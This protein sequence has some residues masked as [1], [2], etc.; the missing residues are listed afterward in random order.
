MKESLMSLGT[1]WDWA[2]QHVIT[3]SIHEEGRGHEGASLDDAMD[4]SLNM[5]I[6]AMSAEFQ[7]VFKKW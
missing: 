1:L 5:L 6:G 2:L 4:K 3:E 7:V